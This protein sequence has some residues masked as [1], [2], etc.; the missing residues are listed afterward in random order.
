M[1]ALFSWEDCQKCLEEKHLLNCMQEE[2]SK[3]RIRLTEAGRDLCRSPGSTPLFEQ[4]HPE[5]VVQDHV[6]TAFE[7]LQGGR[8]YNISGQTVAGLSHSH[9]KNMLPDV[10]RVPPVFLSAPTAS[11]SVTEQH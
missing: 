7:Y 10:Q 3:L 6:Q 2:D 4:G 8:P 11:G 1:Q 9:S 5:L